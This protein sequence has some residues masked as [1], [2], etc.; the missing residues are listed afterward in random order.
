MEPNIPPHLGAAMPSEWVPVVTSIVSPIITATAAILAVHVTQ[1]GTAKKDR[2]QKELDL[3]H[4][5]LKQRDD[6]QR[7]TLLQM[8]TA[9][10]KYEEASARIQDAWTREFN[11]ERVDEE[12]VEG[13]LSERVKQAYRVSMTKVEVLK[14]RILDDEL[15]VKIDAA[16]LSAER[17]RAAETYDEGREHMHQS[18]FELRGAQKRIGQVLRGLLGAGSVGYIPEVRRKGV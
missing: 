9:L 2:E 5:Q 10:M 3:E 16:I 4:H 12:W 14:E 7:K 11:T 6:F 13:P 1:R 8:Q 17:M 15:R 18:Y